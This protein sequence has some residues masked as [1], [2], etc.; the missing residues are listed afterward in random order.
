MLS[1]AVYKNGPIHFY[2]EAVAEKQKEEW[3]L[4]AIFQFCIE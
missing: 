3:K 2:P 1:F 4:S